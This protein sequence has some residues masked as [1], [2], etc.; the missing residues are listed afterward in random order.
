MFDTTRPGVIDMK[1]MPL[2][3][4]GVERLRPKVG[5]RLSSGVDSK[6]WCW[7]T[8]GKGA[9]VDHEPSAIFDHARQ[10]D[11]S[12]ANTHKNIDIDDIAVLLVLRLQHLQRVLVVD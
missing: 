1:R 7:E 8:T 5:E 3:L 4:L 6:H 9:Q 2:F 10:H 12:H 11:T